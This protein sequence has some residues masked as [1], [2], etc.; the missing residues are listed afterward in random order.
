MISEHA[1]GEDPMSHKNR[2]DAGKVKFVLPKKI[3]KVVITKERN[4]S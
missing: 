2:K 4:E 1:I 3:G